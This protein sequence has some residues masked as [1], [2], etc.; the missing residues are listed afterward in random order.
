MVVL[1]GFKLSRVDPS[2]YPVHH[3][4]YA[5][6]TGSDVPPHISQIIDDVASGKSRSIKKTFEDL[7]SSIH[8]VSHENDDPED[9]GEEY[10]AYDEDEH[11]FGASRFLQPTLLPQKLQQQVLYIY[12]YL[13]PLLNECL[14]TSSR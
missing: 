3:T 6:C 8:E 10:E 12:L 2:E 5:F 7:L 9:E 11:D 14:V 13:P 1:E 4:F